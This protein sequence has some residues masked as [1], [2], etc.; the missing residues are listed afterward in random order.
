[1]A[2]GNRPWCDF[3]YTTKGITVKRI[4]FD[5]TFWESRLLPKFIDFYDNC[6]ASEIVSPVH[7]LGLL[8]RNLKDSTTEAKVAS[9]SC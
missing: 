2:V 8:L 6:V 7:V 3:V 1:M 5:S 9:S 4:N